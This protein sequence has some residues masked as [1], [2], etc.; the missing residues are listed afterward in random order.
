[1]GHEMSETKLLLNT[2]ELAELTGFSEGT[3][4][5]WV[6][7]KRVPVVRISNRCVRFLRSEIEKWLGEMAV[8]QEKSEAA[9]I[10]RAVGKPRKA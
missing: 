2:R 6:S 1:M 4:R 9:R 5:H 10:A 7:E 3:L 8:P